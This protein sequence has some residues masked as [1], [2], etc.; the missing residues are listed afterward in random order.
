MNEEIRQWLEYAE[1]DY[2]S[3]RILLTSHLYNPC[4]YHAQQTIEKYLKAVIAESGL[5]VQRTHS[6]RGLVNILT[7]QGITVDLNDDEIDL[8]DSIFMPARYPL[9]SAL[10][11]F[12]PDQAICQRCLGLAE[13]MQHWTS[14]FLAHL[15]ET[16]EVIEQSENNDAEEY[17]NGFQTGNEHD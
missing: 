1:Q 16:R 10:P 8:I 2:E 3:A 6:I 13:R 14:A 11:A 9:G 7:Q 17:P 12:E 4:L 5:H 15:E